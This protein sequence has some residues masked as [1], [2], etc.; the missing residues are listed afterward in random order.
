ML[1]LTGLAVLAGAAGAAAATGTIN[2]SVT[3]NAASA[4]SELAVSVTGPFSSASGLPTGVQIN[5]QNGFAASARSV[6]A[7]CTASQARSNSCPSN[8]RIGSGQA[9]ATATLIGQ[10]TV[11]LTLY[12]GAPQQSG[13]IASVVVV[14]TVSG[15][16]AHATGR[17]FRPVG[18]GLE[19]LFSSLPSFNIPAGI[20]VT[21]DNLSLNAKAIRTITK[22]VKHHKHKHKIKSH[23]SLITNPS[24]CASGHWSGQVTVS[25]ANGTPLSQSV[26]IPCSG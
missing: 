9:T 16:S 12:L 6:A 25:F 1:S 13:D 3:P 23:Y 7:L 11:P 21:L 20:T 18:G 15:S 22:T 26:T 19:L 5:V 10:V 4:R 14:G 2:V 17:L 24:N 8:S